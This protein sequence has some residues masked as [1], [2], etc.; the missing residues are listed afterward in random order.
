VEARPTIVLSTSIDPAS[1]TS[2]LR[3]AVSEV[4]A[5]VPLDQIE[6][7]QQIV[8]G[9]VGQ[10]RFRAALLAM[11]ALLA[12]FVASI[13]LYGV[14]SYLVTQRIREFGIRMAVGASRGAVLRLVL[15]QAVKLL[16]MGICLG[17]VG[18]AILAR[19]IA[20]LLFGV[21][22]FDA[23]TIAGVSVLLA[24]VA[25]V[26]CYIPAQRAANADPMESLI[27]E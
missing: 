11:F 21:A 22:P 4:D 5:N 3:K 20:S 19:L 17:L 6:T 27:Y 2:A 24:V 7:M 1:V 25:L 23:A 8:S 13:G 12:L 10:S 16:S 14:M 18:A 15:G 9:S 26:A